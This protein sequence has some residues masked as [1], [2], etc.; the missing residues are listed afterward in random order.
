MK[1]YIWKHAPNPQRVI[2]FIQEKKIDVPT[3]DVG[4]PKTAHLSADYLKKT[5]HRVVP[6][7]E[8]EDGITISESM[9]ICRYLETLYPHNPLFGSNPTQ[10]AS[11]DMWERI[12]DI[13]GIGAAS[14]LF[15]NSH[16]AFVNRGLAGQLEPI[17]QIP[18]LVDRGKARIILFFRKFDIQIADR[19][20]VVGDNF[21]VADITAFCATRFAMKVCKVEIPS[22]YTNFRRWFNSM[23]DRSSITS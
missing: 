15:R 7:L 16:P 17:P 8:L 18:E 5:E 3:F 22:Q 1:L 6:L 20:Y 10:Q 23:K 11:I 19:S 13:E 4:E 14:E 21:S 12:A 9:A 2:I